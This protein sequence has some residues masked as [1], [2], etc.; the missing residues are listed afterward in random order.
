MALLRQGLDPKDVGRIGRFMFDAEVQRHFD[1]R[2]VPENVQKSIDMLKGVS[3]HGN[4]TGTILEALASTSEEMKNLMFGLDLGVFGIQARAA[5]QGGWIPGL[6]GAVNRTLAKMH[7]PLYVSLHLESNL[8]RRMSG[9]SSMACTT[10]AG[11]R[12]RPKKAS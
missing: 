9:T 1:T 6:A 8:P 3:L 11:R 5:L 4:T 7:S 12:R 2:F 10:G